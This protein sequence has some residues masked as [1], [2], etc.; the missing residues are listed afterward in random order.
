MSPQSLSLFTGRMLRATRRLGPRRLLL[1]GAVGLLVPSLVEAQPTTTR[2]SVATGGAQANGGS[3]MASVSADGRWVAFASGASNLVAN[4]TNFQDDVFVHDRLTGATTRVSVGPAGVQGNQASLDPAISGDG[5]WVAFRSRATNLVFDDAN[6]VDD[7]FV[8]D[9]QSGIT[10]RVSVASDG[11]EADNS[12][13][14]PA[15]SADGRWVAFES[16]ATKLVP[17]DTNGWADVFVHDRQTG[18]TTRVSVSTIGVEG[19]DFSGA[20][21]ISGDGRWVAFHSYA[22]NLVSGDGNQAP[23]VFVHDRL[24]GTTTLTSTG[25]G[26]A[27]GNSSSVAPAISADGRWVAF[28]SFASNLVASDTNGMADVFVRDQ[29]TGAVTRVGLGPGGAEGNGYSIDPTISGDGRWVGFESAASNLVGGDTNGVKDVFVHDRQT[30]ITVRASVSG[31]GA[32]GNSESTDAAISADGHAVAFSSAASTLVADDTNGWSDLFV[33]DP[34]ERPLPPQGLAAHA[35][36]GN[37]VTLRWAIPSS[38]AA[39]TSF[40]LEGGM[41]PGEVLG[42]IP[43]ESPEPTF[44]FT[45]PTGAFYVR[46]HALNGVVKSDASNE[47]RLFVNMPVAPSA[48]TN[49][50]GLVNGFAVGLAWKNTYDGGTPT[51][52]ALDVTGS[53]VAS[54]PLLLGDTFSV[55]GVPPGTYTLAVRALNAFGSSPPSTPVTL[56]VPVACS[57][58]PLSPAEVRAYRV[59]RRV[60]VDWAL[61]T[62]GPA[63]TAYVLNVTGSWVGSLST[64]GRDLNGAVGPGSYTLSVV[65]V[66]P[67]GASVGSAPQTVVVP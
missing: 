10:T 59:G 61:P 37:Q 9:R 29:L 16:W 48:P 6:G 63:P 49:L 11:S 54:F 43:T 34:S 58:A 24:F 40:V 46:L 42:R 14:A 55:A 2:V 20:A 62:G 25:L 17:D 1:A 32:Q 52:L 12:S 31:A 36:R 47:I 19:N 51:S 38:G 8:H 3:A 57:G 23:D 21:S 39:P 22:S 5:R 7:V 33:Y 56:T 53:V 13:A 28:A 27:Q 50:L 65:A 18:A 35:V 26:G 41:S 30:G 67:C 45:A 60:F 4:D 15:I 64:T 66:N 44:I